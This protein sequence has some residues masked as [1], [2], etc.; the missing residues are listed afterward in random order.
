MFS[1][2]K[3]SLWKKT[4]ISRI[5]EWTKTDKNGTSLYGMIEGGKQLGIE[6]TGVKA[7]KVNDISNTDLP[8]IAH[9]TNEQG[10]MHFIIIERKTENK[11]YII[12]PAKGKEKISFT[13]FEKNGLVYCC[14]FRMMFHMA[15]IITSLANISCSQKY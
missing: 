8:L 10:Y 5:R 11:I 3:S 12:D 6:L 4:L 14:L 7:K 1:N 13:E 2:V 15:M 9:I